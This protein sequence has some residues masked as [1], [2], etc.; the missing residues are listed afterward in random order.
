MCE[1]VTSCVNKQFRVVNESSLVSSAA[2]VGVCMTSAIKALLF[3]PRARAPLSFVAQR[4]AEGHAV[5]S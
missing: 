1:K 4:N 3:L 5:P 2:G